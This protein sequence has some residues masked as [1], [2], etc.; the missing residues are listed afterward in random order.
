[1]QFIEQV[2]TLILLSQLMKRFIIRKKTEKKTS[3]AHEKDKVFEKSH[4][5]LELL[6]LLLKKNTTKFSP[7]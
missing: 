2:S 3:K 6:A 7:K 5:L 4:F 1:M